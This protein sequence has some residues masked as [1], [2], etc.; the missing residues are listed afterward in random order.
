LLG[1]ACELFL[2]GYKN[3]LNL[4]FNKK[5]YSYSLIKKDRLERI[6]Q[7]EGSELLKT[8]GKNLI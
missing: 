4:I 7:N 5:E 6:H 2:K 3:L 8:N 1:T